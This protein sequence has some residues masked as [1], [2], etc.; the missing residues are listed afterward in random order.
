MLS[1]KS[2]PLNQLSYKSQSLEIPVNNG[3]LNSLSRTTN[4]PA[5]V[6]A[7][8]ISN[9]SLEIRNDPIMEH[10]LRKGYV[11]ENR[12]YDKYSPS[13]FMARTRL[14][15]RVFILIDDIEY[16]K[17]FSQDPNDLQIEGRSSLTVVPQETKMGVL[18]CLEYGI[19]GAA[20]ICND[21]ICINQRNTSDRINNFSEQTYILMN[22]NK[23]FDTMKF[24]NTLVGYPIIL[25]SEIMNN[26]VRSE[27]NISKASSTIAKTSFTQLQNHKKNYDEML[28]KLMEQ[29]SD[30]DKVIEETKTKL[31]D[32]IEKLSKAYDEIKDIPPSTLSDV[33][34]NSYYAIQK[35]LF[36][37]KDKRT[38]FLNSM[39]TLLI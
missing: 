19:C 35:S 11:I 20:F 22:K 4:P 36:D 8:N 38:Q 12:I 24:N 25:L 17:T 39:N 32:D 1:Q 31:N 2:P 27:H 34:Q 14:G 9:N 28:K 18:Q 7:S 33:D 15:D 23:S 37:L 3:I 10:L 26:P 21:N 13:Y 29:S 5:F 16:R 6:S 30:L